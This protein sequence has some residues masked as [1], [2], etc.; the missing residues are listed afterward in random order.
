MICRVLI[1]LD[2]LKNSAR[3]IYLADVKNRDDL[4]ELYAEISS[5]MNQI[6]EKLSA[7]LKLSSPEKIS[8]EPINFMQKYGEAPPEVLNAIDAGLGN[9][10]TPIFPISVFQLKSGV[11]Y[12]E[13]DPNYD[14]FKLACKV[15]AKRL[16]PNF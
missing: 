9:G 16:Y 4:P 5:R 6:A 8:R 15:S 12:N 13:G 2:A 7:P 10:E 11:N 1:V 14:L 3:L